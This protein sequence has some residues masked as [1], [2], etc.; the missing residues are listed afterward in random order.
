MSIPAV[1]T[2]DAT[3]SI[4]TERALSLPAPLVRA[5]LAGQSVHVRRLLRKDPPDQDEAEPHP[6]VWSRVEQVGRWFHLMSDPPH[7]LGMFTATCP[8][9]DANTHC[10]IREP[11][12]RSGSYLQYA[13]TH[14]T[15][16]L[17]WPPAWTRD[18]RPAVAM[19]RWASRLTVALTDVQ[20]VRLQDLSDLQAR[21]TGVWADDAGWHEPRHLGRRRA[22]PAWPTA[23]AAFLAEWDARHRYPPQQSAANPWVWAV[24][25]AS[26][27]REPRPTRR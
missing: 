2:V 14:Q 5:L 26:V 22:A 11:V 23:A 12:T 21:A 17:L 9:G 20:L 18:P 1:G 6:F 13:T 4:P 27:P 3:A 16:S 7:A 15:S 25:L 10:W 19:P 24:T 8:L